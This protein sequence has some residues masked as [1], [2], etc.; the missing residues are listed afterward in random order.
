MRK[1]TK[2]KTNQV[3]KLLLS[4]VGWCL[5][6]G[7]VGSFDQGVSWMISDQVFRWVRSD[8]VRLHLQNGS[9]AW[10]LVAASR[11]HKLMLLV[12]AATWKLPQSSLFKDWFAATSDPLDMTRSQIMMMMMSKDNMLRVLITKRK[13]M[14]TTPLTWI[15]WRL[16]FPLFGTAPL[17]AKTNLDFRLQILFSRQP[18]DK[19]KDND[20]EKDKGKDKL[21]HFIFFS[22]QPTCA[23]CCPA[24]LSRSCKKVCCQQQAANIVDK[25]RRFLLRII[26]KASCRYLGFDT[27]LTCSS[28]FDAIVFTQI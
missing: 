12:A 27:D 13:T 14:E 25:I 11:A 20:K 15:L 5:W 23:S 26:R 10:L 8:Q 21:I 7:V 4:S 9:K 22:S 3:P 1:L 19:D 16:P 17:P 18:K 6:P 2:V 28:Y 24:C